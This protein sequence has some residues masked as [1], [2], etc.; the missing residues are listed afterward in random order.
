MQAASAGTGTNVLLMDEVS[1]AFLGSVCLLLHGASVS[2]H[3]QSFGICNLSV[4]RFTT[5]HVLHA[6]CKLAADNAQSDI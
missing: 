1:P 6:G 2:W 5:N 4:A 3:T